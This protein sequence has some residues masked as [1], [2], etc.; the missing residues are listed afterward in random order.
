M[1]ERI[2]VTVDPS[3]MNRQ[4][5]TYSFII[6]VLA[7]VLYL[8]IW[9]FKINLGWDILLKFYVCYMLGIIIHELLHAIGFIIFGKA[10]LGD[11]KFGFIMKHMMPYAHCKVPITALSY[12]ISLLL[13]VILTGIV[14]FS[15][16]VILGNGLWVTVSVF[17]IAGG[18]GDWIIFRKIYKYPHDALLEDHPSAIGCVVNLKV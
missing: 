11:I 18:V 13:P 5:I 14:P 3:D 15:L 4:A 17:L 6:T 1:N 10:K 8:P 7:F 12:K 2:E 9:G 16:G